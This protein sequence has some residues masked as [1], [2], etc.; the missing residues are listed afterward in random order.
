MNK[1]V[2]GAIHGPTIELAEGPGVADGQRVEI[3]IKTVPNPGPWGE[4]LRQGLRG[5]LDRRR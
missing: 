2:Q 4:G 3:T 1:H 5:R